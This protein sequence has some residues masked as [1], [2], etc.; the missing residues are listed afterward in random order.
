MESGMQPA[1]AARWREL[2]RY[3]ANLSVIKD[4]MGD[5]G[6]GVAEGNIS[7]LSLRRAIESSMGN[8]AYAMGRGDM[9]DLARIGQSVLRK[10]PDSGTAGRTIINQL[11]TGSVHGGVGGAI[12][13]ALLGP[14]GGAVGGLVGTTLGPRMV[15]AAMNSR[16][17]RGYLTNQMMSQIDPR[18]VQAIAAAAAQQGAPRN[19]LGPR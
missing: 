2:N 14:I 4:A 1:D 11:M 12:G 9:N 16:V 5:A 19:E 3:Y 17:G 13:T 7:P 15:Q 6:A 10:P 18:V 8:D